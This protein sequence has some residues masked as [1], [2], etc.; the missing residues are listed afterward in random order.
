MQIKNYDPEGV[1]DNIK[2]MGS[3]YAALH[4]HVVFS[5]KDRTPS[6]KPNEINRFHDYIGGTIRGLDAFP[7]SV[8]GVADHVHL[9]FGFRPSH[10]LSD[11]IRELKKQTTKW[12]REHIDQSFSWQEGYA[13][14]SVGVSG[15]EAVKHYIATQGE[16][17]R[18]VDYL[19]ELRKMLVEAGVPFED[20]YLV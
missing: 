10:C 1:A 15:L 2:R 9:L 19:G 5:T 8:G 17:H 13:V 11:L 4:C 20:K 18:K 7:E 6:I 3:T 16:H 14:F 12:A